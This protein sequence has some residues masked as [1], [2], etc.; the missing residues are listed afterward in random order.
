MQNYPITVNLYIS[1]IYIFFYWSYNL[2]VIWWGTAITP[3]ELKVPK[4][5]FAIMGVLDAVSS[6][7]QMFAFTY[8]SSGALLVLL[9]Q[10]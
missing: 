2:P 9:L 1:I 10:V 7:M 8:I 4:R 3:E 5:I 6:V